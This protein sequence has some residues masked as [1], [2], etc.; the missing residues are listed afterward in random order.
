MNVPVAKTVA[1]L[2]AA[3]SQSKLYRRASAS[4]FARRAVPAHM[5]Q[6]ETLLHQRTRFLAFLQRR[7][8][9]AAQAEDV[10]QT[11]YMRALQHEEDLQQQESVIGWFYRVLRNA[12]IDYYRRGATRNEALA[13]WAREMEGAVTM[14]PE[15]RDAVCE[16]LSVAIEGLAPSYA[17]VLREVDLGEEPLAHFAKRHN[18]TQNNATVRVHRARAALR[19]QLIRCCGACAEHHCEACDC[20][21]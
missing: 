17:E 15:L 16:C 9:D 21:F 8:P 11:A 1:A 18:L 3:A 10:L 5:T 12:V 14:P 19:K 4:S 13:G 6:L 2:S 7:I 20:R